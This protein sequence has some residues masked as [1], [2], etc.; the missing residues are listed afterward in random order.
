MPETEII[1]TL[2]RE[3]NFAL[4]D[5]F[6]P[7]PFGTRLPKQP[8]IALDDFNKLMEENDL[9]HLP[10]EPTN[11]FIQEPDLMPNRMSFMYVINPLTNENRKECIAAFKRNNPDHV[12]IL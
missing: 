1:E 10:L 9:A 12:T 5:E 7:D 11:N 6:G 3:S 2:E 8:I 4:I